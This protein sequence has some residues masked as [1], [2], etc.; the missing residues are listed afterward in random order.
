MKNAIVLFLII[1]ITSCAS[2][3]QKKQLT[4]DDIAKEKY[5]IVVADL[6]KEIKN[7]TGLSH[8]IVVVNVFANYPANKAGI[9]KGDIITK[10]ENTTML[11]LDSFHK[12]IINEVYNYD[13]LNVSLFRDNKIEKIKMYMY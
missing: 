2:T 3:K 10:I 4:H 7:A 8:G 12:F 9:K 1:T 6:D 11:S 13:Q 5:G